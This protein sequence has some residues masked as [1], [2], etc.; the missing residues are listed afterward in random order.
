MEQK[1][2]EDFIRKVVKLD[3]IEFVGLAKIL[4]TQMV[5]E[6]GAIRPF[7]TVVNEMGNKFM[8]LNRKTRREIQKL[9]QVVAKK[10]KKNGN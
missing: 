7:N 10:E 6:E 2:F 9:L 8:T 3:P 4:G 5:D 1:I